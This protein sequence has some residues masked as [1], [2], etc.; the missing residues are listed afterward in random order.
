MTEEGG[1]ARAESQRV[2]SLGL[3]C[4]ICHHYQIFE[5]LSFFHLHDGIDISICLTVLL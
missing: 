4:A 3:N 5:H 1:N 2:Q